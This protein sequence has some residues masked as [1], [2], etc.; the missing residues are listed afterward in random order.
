MK[1]PYVKELGANQTINTFFLVQNKDIGQ[2]KSGEPYLSLILCDR[3][4]ELDAK[5]WDNV[6]EVL[7]TFE[8]NDFVKVKGLVQIFHNRPQLT[9]HKMQRVADADVDYADYFPASQRDP[10]EMLAELRGIIAGITNPHLRA[11]LCA[12]LDDEEIALR[13][14][15][16]PA[17]KQIHHAYLGGLIEHVLSLCSMARLA[18][19]HYRWIDVDLLLAGVILHD[20]GKIYELS[21]DRGF[22]YTTEGQLLG[23]HSHRDRNM[24]DKL[25][26]GRVAE[27]ALLAHLVDLAD[28]IAHHPRHQQTSSDRPR[29]PARQ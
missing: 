26:L 19:S 16:A 1:S 2:K 18:A 11:L 25:P 27:S 21:Y 14:Q 12:L 22:G 13:F 24:S 9:I 7:E 17:A 20:I 10:G 4:G 5:M 29:L 8:R 6:A 3:T 23:D 15:K 28:I